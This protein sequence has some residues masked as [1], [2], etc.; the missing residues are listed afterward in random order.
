MTKQTQTPVDKL[1]GVLLDYFVA[2][3][4]ECR[5][6][7]VNNDYENKPFVF[8]KYDGVWLG[9]FRPSTDW[10]NGGRIIE[11]EKISLYGY[12]SEWHAESFTDKGHGLIEDMEGDTPLIAAMRCYV[13][14][15]LGNTVIIPAEL[16]HLIPEGK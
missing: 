6:I 2:V 14:S 4:C 15:K 10:T 8:V 13:A 12:Y 9:G 11:R 5:V 16:A 3:C 7:K 1:E